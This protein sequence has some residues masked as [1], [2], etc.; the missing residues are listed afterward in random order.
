MVNC[1][2]CNERL[3]YV[4][5]GTQGASSGE[6]APVCKNA[7]CSESPFTA[8]VASVWIKHGANTFSVSAS[9]K[10]LIMNDNNAVRY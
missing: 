6:E 5:P 2:V 3:V 1:H 10:P 7:G 4:L 8:D 9:R